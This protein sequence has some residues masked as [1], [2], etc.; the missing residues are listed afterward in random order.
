MNSDDISNAT[1]QESY[2]IDHP[3][4][5]NR[6]F[7]FFLL[8]FSLKSGRMTILIYNYGYIDHAHPLER[9]SAPI[10]ADQYRT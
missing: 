3:Y 5:L 6:F 8:V 1:L 9:H 7:E 4:I 10:C 2:R